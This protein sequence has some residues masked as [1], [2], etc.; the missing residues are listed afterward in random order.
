MSLTDRRVTGKALQHVANSRYVYGQLGEAILLC[1]YVFD[2]QGGQF[3][4]RV[5]DEIRWVD[6]QE[7][8]RLELTPAD[9]EI[10]AK[11]RWTLLS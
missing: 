10:A 3:E 1:A 5:H 8:M 7:L 4:L 2:W 6:A 11:V 9:V